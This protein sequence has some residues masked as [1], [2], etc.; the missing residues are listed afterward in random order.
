MDDSPFNVV[1]DKKAF[2]IGKIGTS[3]AV[4]DDIEITVVGIVQAGRIVPEE[5]NTHI[6]ISPLPDSRLPRKGP[7]DEQE[8]DMKQRLSHLN[9]I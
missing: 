6:G 3:L 1:V 4:A 8:A 5:R 7:C 9:D 2:E